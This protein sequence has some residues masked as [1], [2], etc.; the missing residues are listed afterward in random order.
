MVPLWSFII[1]QTNEKWERVAGCLLSL[2]TV[3]SKG[4]R[5]W[6]SII[7][8]GKNVSDKFNDWTC[9]IHIYSR[10]FTKI[11]FWYKLKYKISVA[12][13]SLRPFSLSLV[14]TVVLFGHWGFPDPIR[15]LAGPAV[16]ASLLF[17]I[18]LWQ[19]C[20]S[21]DTFFTLNIPQ[22]IFRDFFFCF[23]R[24]E[25]FWVCFAFDFLKA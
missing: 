13:N 2:R 22:N 3:L 10:F 1:Q 24:G 18:C 20:N 8:Q 25:L 21:Q 11:Q 4:T 7:R 19:I 17:V 14:N 5:R 9:N 15:S 16:L 23:G 6:T 12:L